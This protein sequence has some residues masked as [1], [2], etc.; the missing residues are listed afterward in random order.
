MEPLY[1]KGANNVPNPVTHDNGLK[2][3]RIKNLRNRN[4]H[5]IK[6]IIIKIQT[7]AHLTKMSVLQLYR[8]RLFIYI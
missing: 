3:T 7:I 8:I 4:C 2:I 5:I 6:A 1:C